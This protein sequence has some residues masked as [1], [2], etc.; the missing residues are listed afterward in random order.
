MHDQKCFCMKV[1]CWRAPQPSQLKKGLEA[2]VL[3]EALETHCFF[4]RKCLVRVTC[5]KGELLLLLHSRRGDQQAW[6]CLF[7]DFLSCCKLVF[8]IIITLLAT[9]STS[10]S[11]PS[12]SSI[13]FLTSCSLSFLPATGVAGEAGVGRHKHVEQEVEQKGDRETKGRH[14][15]RGEIEK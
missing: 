5:R 3:S 12:R 6:I 4:P 2:I 7:G 1:F 11:L 14:L 10:S 13:I 15:K 8:S 9:T